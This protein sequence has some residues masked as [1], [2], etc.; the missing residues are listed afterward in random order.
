MQLNSYGLENFFPWAAPTLPGETAFITEGRNFLWTSSGVRSAWSLLEMANQLPCAHSPYECAKLV[1]L[2]DKLLSIQDGQV[3]NL[4]GEQAFPFPKLYGDDDIRCKYRWS[5]TCVGTQQVF[6]HPFYPLVMYDPACGWSYYYDPAWTSPIYGVGETDN[7]LLVLLEDTVVFSAVDAPTKFDYSRKDGSGFQ[8]LN[9]AKFGKPLGIV[10][11]RTQSIIFTSNGIMSVRPSDVIV[12]DVENTPYAGGMRL[13]FD[14]LSTDRP[15]SSP[16]AIDKIDKENIIWFSEKG[17]IY[18]LADTGFS[19]VQSE[20]S[21]YITENCKPSEVC[22]DILEARSAVIISYGDNRAFVLQTNLG[23]IGHLDH[24]FESIVCC[25]EKL[26]LRRDDKIYMLDD[27]SVTHDALVVTS[28]LR[29][30]VLN[31]FDRPTREFHADTLE[32]FSVFGGENAKGIEFTDSYNVDYSP[33]C[34]GDFDQHCRLQSNIVKRGSS[35]YSVDLQDLYHR[36]RIEGAFH[37]AGYKI[38]GRIAGKAS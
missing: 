26:W 38:N 8:S 35:T 10:S 22:I 28:A 9:L 4:A 15:A 36:M 19:E 5:E 30:P 3:I 20:L 33:S 34:D 2:D 14:C 27:M 16:C 29:L 13:T 24:R 21:S 7:R 37:I 12:Y 32:V 23:K 11:L 25:A 6:S 31:A 1:C 18:T 17:G